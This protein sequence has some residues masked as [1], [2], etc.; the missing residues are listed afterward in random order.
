LVRGRRA[1]ANAILTRRVKQGVAEWHVRDL[2]ERNR[3]G[4]EESVRQG[5]HTGGPVP[6]GYAL[7]PHTHPNPQ[8]A[9]EGKKKHRL[10]PDPVHGPIVLMIFSWYCENGL[11]LGEICDR[12]NADLERFPPPK[13]NRKDE[14]PLPQT[15]SRSQIQAMLR[16]PKYTGHNVW[17]GCG[18]FALTAYRIAAIR[19]LH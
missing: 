7:E 1:D 18:H 8:K 2:I 11:G 15:W 19:E 6:Y 9:R 10:I 4:I 12:L 3:R 13:R 17:A 5:W 14:M 16:N